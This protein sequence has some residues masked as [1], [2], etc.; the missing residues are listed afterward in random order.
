LAIFRVRPL[1]LQGEE[2]L[3]RLRLPPLP[4]IPVVV[5]GAAPFFK[6]QLGPVYGA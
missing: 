4:E 6:R 3:P 1:E 2:L 5:E